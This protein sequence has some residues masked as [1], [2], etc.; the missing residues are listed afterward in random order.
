MKEQV[1]PITAG[2]IIGESLI[3]GVTTGGARGGCDSLDRS[4]S[5]R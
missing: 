3:V 4:F 2:T 5:S 1:S